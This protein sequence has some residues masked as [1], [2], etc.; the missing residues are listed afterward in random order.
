MPEWKQGVCGC[1][2]DCDVCLCG[3]CCPCLLVKRNADDLGKE[4]L[5]YCLLRG[6]T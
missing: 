2:G 6:R 4:G 5:L 3:Y 1:L